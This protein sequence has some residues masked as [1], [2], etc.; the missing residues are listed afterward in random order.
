MPKKHKQRVIVPHQ[1]TRGQLSRHQRELQRQRYL[2]YAMA[3][4][5]ALVVIIFGYVGLQEYVLKPAQANQKLQETVATVGDQKIT[6]ATYNKVRSWNI[7]NQIRYQEFIASQGG[8]LG[9][10]TTSTADA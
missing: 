1:M 7:Y 5:L 8:T 10:G 3:G 2:Y 9:G 4:V 6:R